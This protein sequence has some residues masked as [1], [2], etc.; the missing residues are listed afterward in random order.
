MKAFN[1]EK[2]DKTFKTR[3]VLK[4]PEI[5]TH[6]TGD[7]TD[8]VGSQMKGNI[9]L[10]IFPNKTICHI[11]TVISIVDEI[12]PRGNI[13]TPGDNQVLHVDHVLT[14]KGKITIPKTMHEK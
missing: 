5:H 4:I 7:T 10:I 2:H 9:G 8:K 6:T 1:I 12:F 13:K 14:T 11:E 3:G